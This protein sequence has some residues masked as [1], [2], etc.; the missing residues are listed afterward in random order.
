MFNG[1]RCVDYNN[2]NNMNMPTY[3]AMNPQ[4]MAETTMPAMEK[5]NYEHHENSGCR[6]DLTGITCS[7]VFECP[8]ERCIH[9]NI[10][11][12]VPHICPVNTRIINHHIY[13]HTYS[14]S[15]SCCEENEVCNIQEGNCNC[16]R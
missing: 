1:F 14:P 6:N 8:T 16:F 4:N 15:Y 10:Y 7:P 2:Y 3:E 9:R 13:K 12:C 5:K 11:H